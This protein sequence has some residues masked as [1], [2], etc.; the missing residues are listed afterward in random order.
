MV[1]SATDGQAAVT[2]FGPYGPH[3][4]CGVQFRQSSLL[5]AELGLSRSVIVS[6]TPTTQELGRRLRIPQSFYNPHTIG[7]TLKT[8]PRVGII[9]V[10]TNWVGTTLPP[11]AFQYHKPLCERGGWSVP[12]GNTCCG[13][14]SSG[15]RGGVAQ[16]GFTILLPCSSNFRE[17]SS[18]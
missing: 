13:Y 17:D 11:N 4:Q 6:S 15:G 3:G 18:L 14:P 9:S 16:G 1:F 7:I 5:S 2:A 12:K 8:C 10:T